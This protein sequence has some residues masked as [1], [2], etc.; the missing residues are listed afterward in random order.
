MEPKDGSARGDHGDPRS[1]DEKW[2]DPSFSP[3]WNIED[4]AAPVRAAVEDGWLRGRTLL[5]VG[6]GL[7]VHSAWLAGRGFQVLGIDIAPE[8]IARA[9]ARWK[10]RE[11][12]AFEVVD[13]TAPWTPPGSFDAILDRGCLHGINQPRRP[14]YAHNLISWASWTCRFLLL[15]RAPGEAMAEW[16]EEVRGLFSPA[17]DLVDARRVAEEGPASDEPPPRA[18]YRLVRRLGP[19][20]VNQS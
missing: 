3:P 2:R 17:F 9:R 7:G 20:R 11:R 14:R 13:A 10:G 1:W 15:V 12:L 5:D 19:F 18:A 4:V 6:C 16:T 8:V